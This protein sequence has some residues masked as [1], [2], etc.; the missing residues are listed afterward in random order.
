MNT[1]SKLLVT[2]LILSSISTS[3]L[4]GAD[5]NKR[6]FEDKSAIFKFDVVENTSRF[7]FDN[8]PL[9]EDGF[10]KYGNSFITQGYIYPKGFLDEHEGVYQNGEPTHPEKV[11]G[12]WTCRGY[13]IGNGGHTTSGPMVITTQTYD[14]FDKP[15]YQQGKYSTDKLMITEGYEIADVNRQISRAITGGTGPFSR[16]RGEVLQTF[17]GF[18]PYMGVRLQFVVKAATGS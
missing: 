12:I 13:F 11:L 7:V 9:F 6:P 15:G 16:A 8:E 3:T 5:S 17:L 10:P 1:K 2:L 14:F 4:V 18:N